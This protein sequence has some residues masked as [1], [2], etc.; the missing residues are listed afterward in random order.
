[1]NMTIAQLYEISSPSI[2]PVLTK[3]QAN[4]ERECDLYTTLFYMTPLWILRYLL[5]H[6]TVSKRPPITFAAKN[7]IAFRVLKGFD[8]VDIRLDSTWSQ[9]LE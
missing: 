2:V 6:K 4:L 3:S 5:S 1:M 7:F 9:L 8:N